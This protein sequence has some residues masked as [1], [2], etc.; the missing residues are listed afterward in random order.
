MNKL[1]LSIFISNLLFSNLALSKA[2]KYQFASIEGLAEQEIA[3]IVLPQI[4]QSIGKTISITPLPANRAQYEANT[5]IKAGETLRIYTY[6]IENT[7]QTR[8][9]TPYYFLHTAAFSLKNNQVKITGKDDLKKYRVG[10]INGVKHTENITKGLNKIYNS[11]NTVSLFQQLLAGNIDV[12]L[13]NLSDGELLLSKDKFSNVHVINPSLAKL[14]LFHYIHK[15]HQNLVEPI[16]QAIKQLQ[17]N[18]E[19]D[20]MLSIAEKAILN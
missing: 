12:A 2:V 17:A 1:I 5:G 11:N 15:S 3:R 10:K 18:G 19:L 6:G 16:N 14:D 7:N 4:Y 9:P 20:K 8:V 13:T